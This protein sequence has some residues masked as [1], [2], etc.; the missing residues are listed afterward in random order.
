MGQQTHRFKGERVLDVL[1]RIIWLKQREK[2]KKGEKID[3]PRGN[4]PS[5]K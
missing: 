1:R 5:I 4:G 2:K 3:G